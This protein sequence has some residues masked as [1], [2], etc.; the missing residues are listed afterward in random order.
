MADLERKIK[1]FSFI[2]AIAMVFTMLLAS[3]WATVTFVKPQDARVQIEN[4]TDNNKEIPETVPKESKTRAPEPSTLILFGSGLFGMVVSF[5]RK[6]YAAIKRMF[7]FVGALMGLIVLSPIML[8]VAALVKLTSKGPAIYSQIRCGK[9][10][11]PFRIYKFRS[12]RVDAEKATGAVWAAKNDNRLS[13]IGIFLRK[14]HLD[15]LPQLFNVLK[16]EMSI[17]GPRPERPEFIGQLAKQ[18]PD[19]TKRLQV[20]PGITGLAQVWH[21]YDETIEDVKKKVKYDILYIKNMCL[22]SDILIAIRTVRVMLTGE[23]AR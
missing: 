14:S 22:W 20:K 12:M 5:V 4:T 19:Y 16:G 3:S 13:P 6:T 8:L 9:D 7:D 1:K 11:Q 15:E 18:I 10:G 21:R 23:G 2:A 17:I